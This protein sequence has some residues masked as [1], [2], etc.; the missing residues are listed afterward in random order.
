M[1]IKLKIYSIHTS[2]AVPFALFTTTNPLLH[3]I[4]C[5]AKYGNSL[6]KCIIRR[7]NQLLIVTKFRMNLVAVFVCSGPLKVGIIYS[8]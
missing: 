2:A 5:F 8:A 6:G 7:F 1:G 3:F 4:P